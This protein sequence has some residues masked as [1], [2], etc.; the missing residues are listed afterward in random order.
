MPA[1]HVSDPWFRNTLIRDAIGLALHQAMTDDPDIHLFGEGC[2]REMGVDAGASGRDSPDRVHTLP[3]SEDANVNFAVGAALLGVRPVVDV[4]TAD[5][6]FRA[7]DSIC[8]TAAKLDFVASAGAPRRTIVI[9]SEFLTDGPTTGQ[10]PEAIL[11]HIPGICVA[12]PSTPADAHGMTLG[13]LA[14]PGV[15]VLFEDRTILD[16]RTKDGDRGPFAGAIPQ[17]VASLRRWAARPRLTIAAYGVCR[18]M[19]EEALTEHGIGDV[20]LIDLRSIQPVDWGML[21]R[22]LA[23]TGRLLVIEPDVVHGGVGAEIVAT[24]ASEGML[25]RGARRVGAQRTTLPASKAL[26]PLCMPTDASILAAIRE[27]ME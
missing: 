11:A 15:T 21:R 3:I 5:F 12:I 14:S 7:M 27:A 10:R 2:E 16:A 17:G 1:V 24:L 25:P 22:S 20:D 18:Q 23:R 8:N 9:R 19:A 4:I 26:H 13:A 6:L